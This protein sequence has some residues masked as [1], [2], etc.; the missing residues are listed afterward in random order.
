MKKTD[1]KTDKKTEAVND[2]SDLY[3]NYAGSDTGVVDDGGCGGVLLFPAILATG[4]IAVVGFSKKRGDR[5]K[6]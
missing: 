2:A 1:K 6:K 3:T 5:K 4:G